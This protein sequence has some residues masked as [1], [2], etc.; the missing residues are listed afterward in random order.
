MKTYE[1]LWQ[2][3]SQFFL[4]WEMFQTKVVQKI[5]THFSYAWKP[6][7]ASIIIQF[8]SYV[9]WHLSYSLHLHFN[10]L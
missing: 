9:W 8:I 7:N 2:Y 5:K 10:F 6:T 4:E 1:R 3:L